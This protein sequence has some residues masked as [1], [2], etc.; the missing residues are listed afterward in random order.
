MNYT[1]SKTFT[2]PIP[3]YSNINDY[4]AKGKKQPIR[5]PYPAIIVPGI[6]QPVI[7]SFNSYGCSLK[8]KQ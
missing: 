3:C 8:N 5:N 1:E 6:N 7:Q 4:G 2:N